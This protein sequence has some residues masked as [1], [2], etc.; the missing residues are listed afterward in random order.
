MELGGVG[1]GGFDADDVFVE[2]AHDELGGVDAKA[3]HDVAEGAH[4]LVF[5][6]VP[7]YGI[8]SAI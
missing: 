8:V 7:V 6:E 1:A 5:D 4:V 2:L 3:K